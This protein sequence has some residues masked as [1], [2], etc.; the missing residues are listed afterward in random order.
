MMGFSFLA[1]G[2]KALLLGLKLNLRYE[3]RLTVIQGA[4]LLLLLVFLVLPVVTCGYLF[5][6]EPLLHRVIY[7]AEIVQVKHRHRQM[8][9]LLEYEDYSTA[10]SYMSSTYK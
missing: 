10:Y 9:E 5:W 4:V 6:L 7:Q 2:V 1:I 8:I 3:P